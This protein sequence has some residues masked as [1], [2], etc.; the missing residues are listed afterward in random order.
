MGKYHFIVFLLVCANAIASGPLALRMEGKFVEEGEGPRTVHE[1]NHTVY[2]EPGQ[3]TVA[4]ET[5]R[6]RCVGKDCVTEQ[7]TTEVTAERVLP[8]LI[9]AKVAF[10][11]KVGEETTHIDGTIYAR[12]GETGEFRVDTDQDTKQRYRLKLTPILDPKP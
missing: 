11:R 6:K 8:D 7:F 9:Q 2:A 3:P 4:D 5:R 12:P 10:N 1:W